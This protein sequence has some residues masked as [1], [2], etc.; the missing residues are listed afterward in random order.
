[1][2]NINLQKFGKAQ[3]ILIFP[4]QIF[5]RYMVMFW[6]R[7]FLIAL[8]SVTKS[9]EPRAQMINRLLLVAPFN[10]LLPNSGGYE[11]S[12][13]LFVSPTDKVNWPDPLL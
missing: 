11:F 6:A 1:M 10:L 5:R 7:E 4:C 8:P 3:A 9:Q 13:T 2:L 12:M